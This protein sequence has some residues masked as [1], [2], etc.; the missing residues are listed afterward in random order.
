MSRSLKNVSLLLVGLGV[1]IAVLSLNNPAQERAI[2][3]ELIA[4]GSVNQNGAA[5]SG[6]D[7]SDGARY[8]PALIGRG[9]RIKLSFYEL[10]APQDDK[11]GAD[12]SRLQEPTKGI[13]L[14]AE[15]SKEYLVQEDGTIS[16]PIL[17]TFVAE[18]NKPADFQKQLESAFDEFLGRKGF[19]DISNVVKQPIYVVGKVKNSGSFDYTPGM[20]VLHAVAL[21]GGFD[22]TPMEPWQV[23]ELSRQSEQV[24]LALD[25]AVRLIARTVAIE[26]SQSP[27]PVAIP[28][29][30]AELAGQETATVRVSEELA[31]RRLA[32]QS[33]VAESQALKS[34]VEA[35]QWDFDLR[36]GRLPLLEQS[37]ALRQDRLVGLSKLAQSGNLGR[38]V[39]LQA[40]SEL[41]DVEDRRQ[42]TLMSIDVAKDRLSKAQQDLQTH[43]SGN[44]VNYEKDLLEA[45]AEASKAV[46][47]GDSAI[48]MMRTIA[49]TALASPAAQGTKFFIVRRS[50]GNSTAIEASETTPLEPGDL[51]QAGNMAKTSELTAFDAR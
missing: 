33:F 29:E 15:L 35:A 51:V 49:K 19:V 11:W 27:Q 4:G 16:I 37:I 24:Q 45:R 8:D 22:N 12:R 48:S 2:A 18:L 36:K 39:L 7:N 21:A 10:L 9:D 43:Q 42:E 41:L 38:P 23:A 32:M 47:E 6:D 30:L 46:S 5:V 25:H 17:G 13:Q 1:G 3:A 20:T 31:P 50:K 34:S 44:A 28:N 40:Q 26:A 14:R